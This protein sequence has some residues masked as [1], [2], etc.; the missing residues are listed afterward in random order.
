MKRAMAVMSV[1]V[2]LALVGVAL[3]LLYMD[4]REER[5]LWMALESGIPAAEADKVQA[6]QQ[7]VQPGR[8][9]AA[10]VSGALGAALVGCGFV[11]VLFETPM[12]RTRA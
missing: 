9:R 3:G 6:I 12:F 4:F 10:L 1:G 8:I 7:W 5:A 2:G 11:L